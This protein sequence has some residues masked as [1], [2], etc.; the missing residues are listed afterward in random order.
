MFA[1]ADRQRLYLTSWECNVL[2]IFELLTKLVEDA[3]GRVKQPAHTAV[4]S[5]RTLDSEILSCQKRLEKL[6]CM[7]KECGSS[8]LRDRAIAETQARLTYLSSLD[9]AGVEVYGQSWINFV[10]DGK[11]YYASVDDNP[12]FDYSYI[13]TPVSEDGTYSAD[14]SVETIDR[15]WAGDCLFRY[16]C[17][18]E[19]RLDAAEK[20][21]DILRRADDTPIILGQKRIRVQNIYDRCYHYETIYDKPRV[22]RVDF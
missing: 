10:L 3:G 18:D 9:N 8:E 2:K 16:E 21:F 20:L 13:K 4:I 12:F 17:T 15:S 11:K 14:A 22:S 7:T 19:Q 5:N 1:T 6:N